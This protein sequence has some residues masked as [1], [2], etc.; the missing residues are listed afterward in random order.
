MLQNHLRLTF[1]LSGLSKMEGQT[2]IIKHIL[3]SIIDLHK[4]L[5]MDE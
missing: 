4:K 3:E 1:I 5:F 2:M